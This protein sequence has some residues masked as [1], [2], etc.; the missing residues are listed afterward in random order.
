MR[1]II[2]LISTI[3]IWKAAQQ[4]V[5][6]LSNWMESLSRGWHLKRN[7]KLRSNWFIL[8]SM[9]FN[10]MIL[11]YLYSNISILLWVVSTQVLANLISYFLG[12]YWRFKY[13]FCIVNRDNN[14]LFYWS[15]EFQYISNWNS[16]LNSIW[17]TWIANQ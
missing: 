7:H 10:E 6:Y 11:I 14:E 15:W 8:K 2:L 17:S 3:I 9:H 16:S 1:I 4:I 12:V 5:E 13:M